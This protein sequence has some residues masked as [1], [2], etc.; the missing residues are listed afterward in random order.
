MKLSSLSVRFSVNIIHTV[1]P[2]CSNS[3]GTSVITDWVASCS[4]PSTM[5]ISAGN[6]TGVRTH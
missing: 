5:T 2:A 4:G 1:T 6:A 3:R